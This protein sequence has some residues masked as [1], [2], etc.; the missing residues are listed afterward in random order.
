[1]SDQETYLKCTPM[2]FVVWR[3]CKKWI[4]EMTSIKF[5]LLCYVCVGV[6]MK[7]VSDT[8]GMSAALIL[9]GLKEV[10]VGAVLA[11]FK[12]GKDES[13]TPRGDIK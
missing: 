3:G 2:R 4:I 13:P 10:D 6:S 5:L 11:S 1:M 7:W 8:V 12:P 9:V